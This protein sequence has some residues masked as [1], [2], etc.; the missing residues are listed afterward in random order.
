ML[1][2]A[3]VLVV[4]GVWGWRRDARQF[5]RT[6]PTECAVTGK[7]VEWTLRASGGTRVNRKQR[8]WYDGVAHLELSHTLQGR[9]YAVTATA[10]SP[11]RFEV[12]KSY[13][14]RYDP[15]DPSRVTLLMSFEPDTDSFALAFAVVVVAVVFVRPGRGLLG[16]ATS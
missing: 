12:G 3:A 6:L 13:P 9:R 11:E 2:G 1:A 7:E 5:A 14:C 4:Y 15:G 16:S 8:A 10:P